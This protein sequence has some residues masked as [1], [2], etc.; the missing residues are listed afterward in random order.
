MNIQMFNLCYFLFLALSV[1][2][3]LGL[4]FLLRHKS[5]K[6]KKIV[7]FSLLAFAL[8]LHFLKVFIP[9]YSTDLARCYRDSW[10]I[11]ICGANICLFPFIFLSKSNK[12]KDYMF[13]IGVISGI[14]SILYP[15]EPL[16]KISQSAEW[17]DI[18]R[19]YIHHNILW[20][21][22]LL[23][24]LFGLHKINYRRIV[25]VPLC[26]LTVMGFIMLNQILQSELGY[27]ALRGDDLFNINYKN[28]SLIWE[29]KN[30][31]ILKAVTIF[32]PNIFKTIPVG[33]YAGQEKY[34]PLIWMLF[35][36][37][38][39]L[40]PITFAISMI[41]D[42]KTFVSDLKFLKNKIKGI[43]SKKTKQ[44]L[45]DNENIKILE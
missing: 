26:M 3:F 22:P 12:F 31:E 33:Q 23:M 45:N 13:F 15:L 20:Y 38:V 11:N 43:F 30:V 10:F 17:L 24:V 34:W 5:D 42:R 21:V 36:L 35:P 37:Y 18:I 29:P 28:T 32:C 1:G 39:Y 44:N 14:I 6:T 2:G 27:I 41:F 8:L 40:I 4:Y 19:F 25:F 7:L 16:Q 9:P